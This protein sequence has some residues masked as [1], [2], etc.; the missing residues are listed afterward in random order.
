M[1]GHDYPATGY[2][3]ESDSSCTAASEKI[4]MHGKLKNGRLECKTGLEEDENKQSRDDESKPSTPSCISK[5]DYTLPEYRNNVTP[6]ID[7]LVQMI[8][9]PS[10]ITSPDLSN[11]LPTNRISSPSH[12]HGD[13]ENVAVPIMVREHLDICFSSPK[14]F[15]S[16]CKADS[17]QSRKSAKEI[18][19]SQIGRE[20]MSRWREIADPNGKPIVNSPHCEDSIYVSEASFLLMK[21]NRNRRARNLQ[22]ATLSRRSRRDSKDSDFIEFMGSDAE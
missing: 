7:K 20:P 3:L 21:S 9:M 13:N 10:L 1:D 17:A 22:R 11:D 16:A 8:N 19:P 5:M 14:P 15:V 6:A 4:S 12:C 18:D 2:F